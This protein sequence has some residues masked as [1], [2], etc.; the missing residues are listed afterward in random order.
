MK[1]LIASLYYI[2]ILFIF[3]ALQRDF[4]RQ[5]ACDLNFNLD[6]SNAVLAVAI[7]L[8]DAM[9]PNPEGCNF[10]VCPISARERN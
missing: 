5:P 6:G 1:S 8:L 2:Y 9:N 3:I 10:E 7:R 4:W